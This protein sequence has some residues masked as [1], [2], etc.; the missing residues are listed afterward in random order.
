M[1]DM[2]LYHCINNRPVVSQLACT[3]IYEDLRTEGLGLMLPDPEARLAMVHNAMTLSEASAGLKKFKEGSPESI[4][5]ATPLPTIYQPAMPGVAL[6]INYDP[7]RNFA[8]YQYSAWMASRA[9][10]RDAQQ[11]HPEKKGT[12]VTFLRPDEGEHSSPDLM[13]DL[14][15]LYGHEPQ[16]TPAEAAAHKE[17]ALRAS[18]WPFVRGEA[19]WRLAVERARRRKLAARM[20]PSSLQ[21]W[22]IVQQ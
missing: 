15:L 18:R 8:T 22:Q 17:E 12:V 6:V 11:S 16:R 1:Q 20:R 3:A 9:Y 21:H 13:K 2:Y 5:V 14:V 10:E 4:L 19:T 7:P